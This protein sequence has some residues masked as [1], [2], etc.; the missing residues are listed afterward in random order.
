MDR[1]GVQ[2]PQQSK[3]FIGRKLDGEII[4]EMEGCEA[5]EG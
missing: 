1:L 5:G 4:A 2:P 3:G